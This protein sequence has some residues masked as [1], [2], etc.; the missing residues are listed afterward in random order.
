MQ[1]LETLTVEQKDGLFKRV[2]KWLPYELIK[3]YQLPVYR[4]EVDAETVL[5]IYRWKKDQK[6]KDALME[7][8]LPHIKSM[9]ILTDHE[10]FSQ[11]NIPTMISERLQQ[12]E[13]GAAIVVAFACEGD[14]TG[15]LPEYVNEKGL[16]LGKRSRFV[17]WHPQDRESVL[18]IWQTAWGELL[19][20]VR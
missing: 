5:F 20:E 8:V 9:V 11:Q 4:V 12:L 6:V 17:F 16:Y 18:K 10:N 7:R 3:G 2:I 13:A 14:M 19:K 15:E 1:I